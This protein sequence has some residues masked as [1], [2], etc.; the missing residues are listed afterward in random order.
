MSHIKRLFKS[1]RARV[2]VV[3]VILGIAVIVSFFLPK[4]SDPNIGL[5]N[6]PSVPT[7]GIT[8]PVASLTVNRSTNLRDVNL[9][10]TRVEEAGAF[11]DDRKQVG[12]YTVRVYVHVQPGDN[13]HDPLGIDYSSSVYLILPDGQQVSPKLIALPPVVFPKQSKDGYLD[14]PVTTQMSLA[15]LTLS[16]GNGTAVAFS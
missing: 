15:S 7:V 3:L 5:T 2:A 14:F 1:S 9:T 10:V 12:A 4:E 13:V 16:F 11:S 8:H 6:D